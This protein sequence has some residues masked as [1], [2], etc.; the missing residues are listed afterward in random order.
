MRAAHGGATN[1]SGSSDATRS[2]AVAA[3]VT[4]APGPVGVGSVTFTV[5]LGGAAVGV[6]VTVPVAAGA[7]S[8]NFALPSGTHAGDYTVTRVPGTLT[9]ATPVTTP[10]TPPPPALAQALQGARQFAVGTGAGGCPAV[11][12]DN[13]DGSLSATIQAFD[14]STPGGARAAAAD[15]TG[16]GKV[17]VAVGTGPGTPNRV[18]LLDGTTGAAP[19]DFQPLEAS[20]AGGLFLA[21][22]DLNADGVPDLIV[23]PDRTGGPIVV[24]YDG[25][26]LAR[27]KVAQLNRYCLE[28]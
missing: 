23:T 8:V 16:T 14:S 27:G 10:V 26:A 28:L 15:F 19:A 1:L 2:L 7:A 25:A 21:V 3:A 5:T 12:V 20:F 17:G 18:R 13:A 22:G 11:K 24:A 4:S 9:L 6:P